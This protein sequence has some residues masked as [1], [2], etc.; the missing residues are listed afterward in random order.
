LF[1]AGQKKQ[2]AVWEAE[3]LMFTF[4]SKETSEKFTAAFRQ[5]IKTC[6]PVKYLMRIDQ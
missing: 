4:D 1:A 5:A 2:L 6:Q 3:T